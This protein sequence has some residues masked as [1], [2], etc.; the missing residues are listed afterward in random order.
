MSIRKSGNLPAHLR[1][2]PSEERERRATWRAHHICLVLFPRQNLPGVSVSPVPPV[3]AR[4]RG[5]TKTSID[6]RRLATLALLL[7]LS[8]IG[9]F[10]KLGPA[11][12]AFDSAA[13]FIAALAF[14][15]AAGALV[16]SI[17]HMLSATV[18]AF[19]L[20]PAFHVLVA[21]T[22]MGVGALG[23]W[24][25]RRWNPYVAAPVIVIANGI[26][27][28]ALLALVPN[29]MGL[30][31]FPALW[32]FLTHSAAWNVVVALAVTAALKRARL[33]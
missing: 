23:G 30:G 21:V 16:C 31:L 28:P 8:A 3:S 22:M 27:A 32:G 18:T 25:A 9:A 19:P 15:P 10:I 13:G 24:V 6:T 1:S 20:T 12:I 29:P 33:A 7:A 17:G 26:A 2:Q 4:G 11:S 14:G 5:D